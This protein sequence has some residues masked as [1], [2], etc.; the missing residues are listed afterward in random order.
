MKNILI[1]F[2]ILLT[3]V[4]FG[5]IIESDTTTLLIPVNVGKSILVDL[6]DLERLK[7][8]EVTYK[9]EIIQLENK[10]FKNEKIITT[11]EEKDKKNNEIIE[12]KDSKYK[13]VDDE[14]K[15][16]RDDIKKI[17]TKN[18]IIEIVGG[19]L[20]TVLTYIIAFK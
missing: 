7:K 6:N 1:L 8:Q 10:V 13:L 12:L 18:I 11:L 4:S 2:F 9:N 15:E 5:Q 19:S 17:K 3:K 14:N 20:I 16:L